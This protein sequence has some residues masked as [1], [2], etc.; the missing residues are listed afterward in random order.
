MTR[1]DIPTFF[2]A[3]GLAPARKI[4]EMEQKKQ[5]M[6]LTIDALSVE[7]AMPIFRWVYPIPYSA[8]T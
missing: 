5:S 2:I 3:E 8:V 7:A 4:H 6:K 1:N